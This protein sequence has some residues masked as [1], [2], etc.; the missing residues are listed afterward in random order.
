MHPDTS[1]FGGEGLCLTTA[2]GETSSRCGGSEI[3]GFVPRHGANG[4]KLLGLRMIENSGILLLCLCQ[5]LNSRFGHEVPNIF[6]WYAVLA[7]E[8]FGAFAD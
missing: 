4:S 3:A 1:A 8:R 7:G 6:K 2:D 5:L